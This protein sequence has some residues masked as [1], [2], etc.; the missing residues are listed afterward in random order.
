MSC[1]QAI[2]SGQT[3]CVAIVRHYI[4]RVRAFNG[5]ASVL[6]TEDGAPV[7]EATGAVRAHGAAA[8]PDRKPS[9]PP[10]IL[11]DLD[12]Y[13]GRRSNTAAWSRRRPIPP[14]SSSSE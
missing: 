9:K 12:K 4:E 8:L 5:V 10:P 11:P 2:R 1:T 14:C 7:P 13:R 6:V 3:T